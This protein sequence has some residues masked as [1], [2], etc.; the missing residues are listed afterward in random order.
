MSQSTSSQAGFLSLGLIG[1]PLPLVMLWMAGEKSCA[2]LA[3]RQPLSMNFA[4]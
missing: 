1:L 2:A 4:G 3:S